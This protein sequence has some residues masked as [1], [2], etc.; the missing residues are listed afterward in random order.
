[1]ITIDQTKCTACESCVKDCMVHVL[2]RGEGGAIRVNPRL[3]PYCL[4]CQ[5]CFA[6][7]PV[8][9]IAI[10]EARPENAASLGALPSPETMMNLLRQRRSVRQW[11]AGEVDAA[12]WEKLAAVTKYLP[13]GC[14]DHRLHFAFVRTRAEMDVF[15]AGVRK[16]I[17]ALERF[18][19][20]SLLYPGFRPVFRDVVAGKDIIFRDAPA[21]IVVSTP[22]NA[23]CKEADPWIAA[24]SL[25][26]LAESL[27]LGTCWC[28]FG[29]HA[30]SASVSL[31]RRLAL[32]KGHRI[33]AVLLVGRPGVVYARTTCPCPP[34]VVML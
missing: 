6:V 18:K 25:A 26:A 20:L 27:G 29:S 1:M 31:K 19:I 10:G 32:P 21:M 16:M 4:K 28:G 15:R 2:E 14:N 17:T 9:A 34:P 7:C 22:K 30:L 24:T 13:T 5:H 11:A 33:G 3:E 23:P 12:L 8:G